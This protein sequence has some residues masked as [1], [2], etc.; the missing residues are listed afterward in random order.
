MVIISEVLFVFA[1]AVL[2]ALITM[3]LNASVAT[4]VGPVKNLVLKVKYTA[5]ASYLPFPPVGRFSFRV[6]DHLVPR[7][8]VWWSSDLQTDVHYSTRENDRTAGTV[9]RP[10]LLANQNQSKIENY[11]VKIGLTIPI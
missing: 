3:H 7:H 6:S 1:S 11:Q 4:S 2:L 9:N 8:V 10:I 5:I